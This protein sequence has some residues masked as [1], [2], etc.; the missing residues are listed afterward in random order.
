MFSLFHTF[1][2]VTAYFGMILASHL[3]FLIQLAYKIIIINH[4]PLL[5]MKQYKYQILILRFLPLNFVLLNDTW[6]RRCSLAGWMGY[7]PPEI[8]VVWATVHLAPP[9]IGSYVR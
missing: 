7:G 6:E 1:P 4:H 2:Y 8:L 9:I 5:R 3:F